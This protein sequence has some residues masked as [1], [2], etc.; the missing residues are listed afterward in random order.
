M[1]PLSTN[2]EKDQS[3]LIKI[4]AG[5]KGGL[6]RNLDKVKASAKMTALIPHDYH[7]LVFQLEAYMLA[8]KYTFRELSILTS[9]LCQFVE[10]TK[11]QSLEYK[12]RIAGDKDFTAKILLAVDEQVN[13]FLNECCRRVDRKNVNKQFINFNKLHM[14]ILLHRFNI[15]F[16]PNFRRKAVAEAEKENAPNGRKKRGG[17]KRKN[18]GDNDNNGKGK[19]ENKLINNH[20]VPEF[21]IKDGETW[22]KR[23]QGKCTDKQV[24]WM[25]AFMCPHY[26]TKGYCW[27]EGCKNAKSHVPTK[28]ITNQ[29]KQEYLGYMACCRASPSIRE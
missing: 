22:E 25:D 28:D 17:G 18:K 2:N 24:K 14:L 15:T 16:P 10:K 26:H 8:S 4:S 20:Q 13:L 3:L 11:K 23:F 1:Q 5:Q 29:K 12:S 21:A 7:T 6:M 19:C 9:Q 27:K